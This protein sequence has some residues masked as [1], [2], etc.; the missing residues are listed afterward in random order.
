MRC[1]AQIRQRRLTKKD[2]DGPAACSLM[3][4]QAGAHPD[5]RALLTGTHIPPKAPRH[6]RGRWPTALPRAPVA[7]PCLQLAG[8]HQ[9]RKPSL[10]C[11][12]AGGNAAADVVNQPTH[13]G[14]VSAR[15]VWCPSCYGGRLSGRRA[16]GE[17]RRARSSVFPQPGRPGWPFV[18]DRPIFLILPKP[19]ARCVASG[20][21]KPS[22]WELSPKE[23][24]FLTLGAS[25]LVGRGCDADPRGPAVAARGARQPWAVWPGFGPRRPPFLSA[26]RTYRTVYFAPISRTP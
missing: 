6:V 24:N 23:W 12:L 16:F 14:R 1:L 2:G 4:W 25:L 18:A 9:A 19:S 5:G 10:K 7:L 8:R 26:N 22:F 21:Q 20:Q 13:D 11:R 17:A 3:S 15:E